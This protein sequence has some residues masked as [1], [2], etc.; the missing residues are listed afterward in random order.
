M[1]E[2]NNKKE[3]Q[4]NW[5]LYKLRTL[6]LASETILI[7]LASINPVY[8][9]IPRRHIKHNILIDFLL[10]QLKMSSFQLIGWQFLSKQTWQPEVI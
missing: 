2:A 4:H 7:N 10:F 9:C 8:V 1:N 3:D 6:V 5:R